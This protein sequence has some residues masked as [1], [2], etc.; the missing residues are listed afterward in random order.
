MILLIAATIGISS[1]GSDFT[2]FGL[3]TLPLADSGGFYGTAAEK[4]YLLY[5]IMIGLAFGP[6]QASSRAFLAQSVSEEE[7]G[8]YFGIY[9]LTGRATSFLAPLT[10]GAVTVVTGSAR[11]GMATLVIF[12]LAGLLILISVQSK[13]K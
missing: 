3:V 9:A 10:V 7:A 2:L 6:V 1:T 13:Q 11:Y 8:R 12:L 5:G 4:V